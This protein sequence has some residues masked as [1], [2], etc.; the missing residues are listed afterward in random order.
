[1][2]HVRYVRSTTNVR[3]SLAAAALP[4][5][6]QP[7]QVPETMILGRPTTDLLNNNTSTTDLHS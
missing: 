5:T 2:D 7:M 4:T 3:A 6:W 1:M